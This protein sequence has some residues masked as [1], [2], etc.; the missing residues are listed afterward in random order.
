MPIKDENYIVIQGWM[1][2]DYGLTGD[3]LLVFALIHGFSQAEYG[4]YVGGRAYIAEWLGCSEKKVGEIIKRLLESEYI[5]RVEM[6]GEKGWKTYRYRS[7]IGAKNARINESNK[8]EIGTP[9]RAKNAH[10]NIINNN[11]E[12]NKGKNSD[13]KTNLCPKCGKQIRKT[14]KQAFAYECEECGIYV[15]STCA[16][17]Q[18][19]IC[20]PDRCM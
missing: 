11:K 18:C 5:M 16:S 19:H 2:N 15:K 4:W 1:I 3:D 20:E 12:K 10:I 7:L 8:G 17:H 13:E 14:H 6:K 9:I